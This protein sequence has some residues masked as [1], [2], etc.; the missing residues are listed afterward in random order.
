MAKLS[1][2]DSRRM[3]SWWWDSHISPKNSKWLQENL[4]DMDVKVKSMIKLLEAEEDSFARRA[5]MYYKKRPELMKMVEDF[6]RAY[7]ALAKRYD[8]ATGVIRH[9]HRTMT[10]AQVPMEF[11][12]DSPASSLSG[13]DP[14]TPESIGGYTDDSDNG[15]RERTSK[16]FIGSF[17]PIERV[18]RGLNFDEAK[19]K[20]EGVFSNENNHVGDKSSSKLE[21]QSDSKEIIALKEAI[22]KLEAEKEASIVQ[23]QQT[24]DK[25][26]QLETEISRTREDFS[27]LKDH[28]NKADTEV[29]ALNRALATLEAEKES[30]FQDYQNC[31]DKISELQTAVSTT[32]DD[33]QKLSE[34]AKSAEAEAQSLKSELDTLAVE[35]DAALNQYME[36]LEI[37]SNMENKLRLAE[38]NSSGFKERAEKAE[39][40]VESLRQAISKLTEEKEST[41]LQYQQCLETVSILE[42]KLT[43]ANKEAKRLNGEIENNVSKLKGAEEQ[44]LIL[45]K[46]NQSLHSELESLILKMGTQSQEL[47]EK[48]KELGRLW[49]TVQA[50][51]LRFVDAE[52]A[53]QTLQHLHAQTQEELRAMASE[54]QNQAQLLKVAETQN[55]SLQDEVLKVKRENKHLDELNSSS[56]LSIQDMR[57]KISSLTEST[58]KLEEEVELRLDQRNALQQEIYCLKEE[59]NDLNMKHHSILDQVHEVGLNP[60][61]LG[62]SVKELQDENSNL[63]ET[64]QRESTDKAALLLKLE[65]MEQLLEK[66][67]L[68]ETSLS[69]LNAE[70]DAVRGKIEELEQSCQSL[71]QE[72]SS[73]LDEKK[74]LKTQLQ[75]TN[76]NLEKITENNTVL[77]LSLSDAHHQ[78]EALKAK[79]KILEDSCQLLVNE[80]ADFMSE[81]DSLTSQLEQTQR[82]LVDLEKLH[83]ELEGRCENLENEKE[84]TLRK[85]EELQV[86]LEAEKQEHSNSV[87]MNKARLTGIQ[88]DMHVQ[89]EEHGRRKTE[90]DHVLDSAI[91]SEIEI[92]VLRTTAQVMKENYCS[93]LAKNRKLIEQ[94]SLSEKEISR[95]EHDNL[96]QQSE[97]RLI[98]DDVST[99]RSGTRQLLKVLSIAED[100]VSAD[101]AELDRVYISQLSSTLQHLKK[102]LCDA[103]EENL[104]WSVAFSVLVAWIKELGL[105]SKNVEVIKGKLEHE[106]KLKT[107]QVLQLQSDSSTLIEM[108]EELKSKLREEDRNKEALMVQIE[109]LNSKLTDMQV[110]CQDLQSEKLQSSEEKRSLMDSIRRSEEKRNVLQEANY[111]LCDKVVALENLSFIIQSFAEEKLRVL[112]DLGDDHNKLN[113]VNTALIGKL[114][115]SEG[116]LEESKLEN[117]HLKETLQKTDD[118]LKAVVTDKDHLSVE[119]ENGKEIL[120][121]MAQE[122]QEAGEKIILAEKLKLELSKSVED[123]RMENNEIKIARDEQESQILKLS[124]DSDNLSKENNFLKDSIRR[125]E[126]K[127]NVLEEENHVLCDEVLALENQS[128]IFQSFAE[129]KQRVL[130][131]LGDDHNKLIVANTALIGKLSVAEGRLEESKLEK[132]HL[133]ERL[134]TTDNELKA[135]ATVKDQLSVEIEN[136]K[137]ILRKM[138]QELQD[139]REKIILA[140][141]MKIELSKSVED[142]RM[143]NNEIKMARDEQESQIL[144]LSTDSDNLSKENN[145]LKDSI[146]HSEEKHNVLEEENYALCDKVLALENQSLIFQSFADEKLRV[147]RDLGD[148]HSKLNVMNTALIGKLNIAE[149]RLEESILENLHLKERLQKTDDELKAVATVKDQLSVEIENG[150]EILVKMAQEL[151]EA[152]EKII[153]AEK[154]KLELSKSVED[155]RMENNEIKMARDEQ[156]SQILKLSTD[157]DNL[158]KEISFLKDSIRH[159]E[160]KHNVLEEENYALCDKVLAL[161]NLSLIFQSFAE[162]KLRVLRDLGG[163]RNNLNVM[164]TAL[165]GKLSV[166]EGRLEESKIE[167]FH[168]K[169]RLQR[170]DN[171]LNAVATDKDQLSVEIEIGKVVLHQMARELHEAGEKIVLAEKKKLE[172]SN[173]VE[174]LRMEYNEVKIA[175]DEQANQILKLSA[176]SDN[177]SKEN[178][179]LR[180]ATQKLESGLQVLQ[181]NHD[182]SKLQEENLRLELDKKINEINELEARAVSLFS[183]LQHSMI[184]QVLY[185]QKFYELYDAC[186]GYIDQNEDLKNQLDAFRPEIVSLKECIFSMEDQTDIHIKF[187]N[188]ENEDL[189]DGQGAGISPE[190]I[191]N[192]DKKLPTPV[193]DLHDLRVRL[194]AVVKAAVEMKELMVQENTYLHSKLDQSSR[195]FESECGKHGRNR[196]PASE[197]TVEDTALLTK[198]IVLDQVSDGSYRYSKKKAAD[199]D[200]QIVEL[201]ETDGTVAH[202]ISKSNRTIPPSRKPKGGS[203]DALDDVD[204]LEI[205]KRSFQDGSKRKVL[206]RL[207]SDVQKLANLQTTV[208]DL[209]TKLEA[210]EKGKRG[211]AVIECEALR[212]QL[213]EADRSVAQLLDLNGRLTKSVD[214]RSFSDSKSSLDFEGE[215]G[216]ARRRRVSE[217]AR[218][219][220][221]KIGRVQL[222][223]Q[224]LQFILLKLDEKDGSSSKM[225]DRRILLRDYLYGGGRGGQRRKKGHFCACVKPSTLE[226]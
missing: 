180:E 99:M 103:D 19:D 171:E 29:A 92:F 106:F 140:E 9:A 23:H 191:R 18:K 115:V 70:L 151:Q 89:Q 212:R 82:R 204:K 1:H 107:E 225:S 95:L 117:L 208:H 76:K 213:D 49:A 67:S 42:Q 194:E 61:S 133:K 169:E 174:D 55:H 62:S 164:N 157:S 148:D 45:E 166:A 165:T 25:L 50:D 154:M 145:F 141:K 217:Q 167:N 172:L 192:E 138:A 156:E 219:M 201:W 52:T 211:K 173:S 125:S 32:Q 126:E 24:L 131:D 40:E 78:L 56:A 81:N 199:V 104:E 159:S 65:I 15:S 136:G 146:R 196:R 209:K 74:T 137:E 147:L 214:D 189:Q 101:N 188:P 110:T 135:V 190:S 181:D 13:A 143:E 10:E 195:Q 72:R 12:D 53:F 8:H 187:Q 59:L 85:V 132:L 127:H 221:E 86:S 113:V 122:L 149:G 7:R 46:S 203:S 168:L 224:K 37:I 152:G 90:L 80:K 202:T 142:L 109:N 34:R 150:K 57:N 178:D 193:S 139:A 119:I 77:Q 128:L 177:L 186:L 161:E 144:K 100:C 36:S 33:A 14:R 88:S 11:A 75:E 176:D 93:L 21:Q 41:A 64:C 30:K 175:R 121:Q 43:L 108:N 87:E 60:E 226:D 38:E 4:T 68:L 16:P 17:R 207:D 129:E 179:F 184:S 185:E 162:E 123:L 48:Q 124:T 6:Y 120:H 205:S 31:L 206:E 102:S 163:D 153:L 44:C 170:T 94:S 3:Y 39:S 220:S 222:E 51:R 66:N 79:S 210:T 97:I 218:R 91:A 223:V 22:A 69:G 84:L 155:L 216:G 158:S 111:V 112:R 96:R 130:R 27:M 58:E 215:D 134:Q 5:E 71:M 83:G 28:A 114:S 197:I 35:K 20:V 98:S 200:S 182:K 63:K 47:T 118:E 54:L 2:L 73:L 160:E 183:Q 116:N 105:H 198:D 26:S